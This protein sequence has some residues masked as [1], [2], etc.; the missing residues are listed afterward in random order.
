L[1]NLDETAEQLFGEALD[2]PREQ[3]A[4]FLDRISAGQQ[5]ALRRRVEKLLDEN[6]RLSGF[7]SV[8]VVRKAEA[9]AAA[10][11]AV[12]PGTRLL[13]RYLIVER[14]GAGGMG[15][16]YRARDEK[17]E[18]EVAI[19]MLQPGVPTG[20]EARS[21]FQREAR[22]LAK[23]SHAHIAAVHDAIEHDAADFIVME[24]VAGESL[25][26]KLKLGA[27]PVREATAIALQV[28]EALEEAHDRG[29]IHRDLKPPNVMITPKG[30]AKVLDFGLAKLLGPT[31]ATHSMAETQGVM[32]TPLYTS[33]EQA[34]GKGVDQRTDLWSLGVLYHEAL[35][36]VA[37]FHGASS[38][39][40]LQAVAAGEFKPVRQLRP[41]APAEAEQVVARALEKDPS[42][43]YATAEAMGRDLADLLARMSA[44][45]VALQKRGRP[46]LGW[47]AGTAL[48]LVGFAAAG[49]WLYRRA[50]ERMWARDEAPAQ[51]DALIGARKPL[52]AFALL[53]RAEKDLPGD[54]RLEQIAEE[55][56]QTIAVMS[57]PAGAEVSIEDYLTPS[58]GWYR[59]GTTPLRGVRIPKG[60]FRWKVTRAGTAD[61]V[62]AP[63]TDAQMDFALAENAKAP[64]G[65]VYVGA[66]EW[67]D[68]EAFLGWLG[69]YKLP[70]Y[71]VDRDEVTNRE[72]Q[73]FVDAGGYGRKEFWPAAFQRDGK[74]LE[75]S[76]G[77]AQFRDTTGRPG[78]S[79]W[80]AGHYPQGQGDFPVSGVSWFEA[81]AYAAFA[82][83]SLPVLAQWYQM[84]SPDVAQYTVPMS[85]MAGAGPAAVGTYQGLGLFGTY[86]TAG[87]VREW[88]AN[89]VDNDLRFILGGSWKSPLYLSTSP[90]ALS[91]YDRVEGNGFRCVRNLGA[92]PEGAVAPFHSVSRDFATYKPASDEVFKA[93][94]L[95]Y[96]YP[97]SPL[98][99][100]VEGVVRETADW[101]EEKVSFDAAYNGERMA[102]HLFL[103]K[104]VRA[105]YQTVLF[106]PSARVFLLPP[107]SN[108]LGD[109]Q[110]FDYILQSGRAVMYPVYQDTYERRVKYRVPG[111][112]ESFQLTTEWYKDAA[113]SLDYLATR[114]DIDSSRLAYLGVS[115]G[116]ADG[117]I[118][119][120]LLQDR[121]RAAIF[122]DGGYF[123]LKPAP[124]TDQADFAPRMKKPVLMVNGRYD[125]TFPV[126]TAQ[127]PMF[128]M[129]GTPAVDKKHVVLD[130]PH[131]V[132]EQRGELVKVVLDWL[133]RYL[134]RV[135]S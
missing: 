23:L 92:V 21:R 59:L 120:A 2:L 98:N 72:Y 134:G 10:G 52:A 65:M 3:R 75:W 125:Y 82:G 12:T 80:A 28:A 107:D 66:G 87:N 50:A 128:R 35:T 31:A 15:V 8:P 71:Y 81:S 27:L 16:V 106:F 99:A 44:P 131:D 25:A 133:D 24:L 74:A 91:P 126:E 84:A 26:A 129:L 130:T 132:T 51:I 85:N 100:K 33:P 86:D 56:T 110:F 11:P 78:P 55:N 88:T 13:D 96:A 48:L 105:P 117:V 41:E 93:Y 76:A 70:A 61:V 127:D 18:R 97:K 58:A 67:G 123:L 29:V 6:D 115:M 112:S 7:L 38:L 19:K 47:I 94:E 108:E 22:A 79:T 4:A 34:L 113:R 69:P 119:T 42:R 45:A 57:E 64:E 37:P 101:R 39:A 135:G 114:G 90:E 36:G 53:Q 54:R 60:Y 124:G 103:P 116:S 40:V 89:V 20:E 68:Y 95:L 102:A 5:P 43:R 111:G 77:M 118:I 1:K 49:T 73:K 30:Q 121:L 104:R 83:K 62:V 32:G 122:L 63:Q 9:T 46:G 109:V 17:L 14:L